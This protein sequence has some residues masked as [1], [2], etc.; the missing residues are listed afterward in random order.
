MKIQRGIS[1][2]KTETAQEYRNTSV[3]VQE[4]EE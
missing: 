2:D 1:T 3:S 4:R